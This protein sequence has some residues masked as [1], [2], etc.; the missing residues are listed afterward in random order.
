VHDQCRNVTGHAAA[1]PTI[2]SI[3]ERAHHKRA[4]CIAAGEDPS[5]WDGRI[6]QMA[7]PMALA[8]R[9][10][11][12]DASAPRCPVR[13]RSRGRRPSGRP[14]GRRTRTTRGSPGAD[15]EPHPARKAAG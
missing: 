3:L 7:L 6:A 8:K 9:E 1:E 4:Q 14:R 13:I 11:R 5:F 12:A 10:I 2:G 15:G